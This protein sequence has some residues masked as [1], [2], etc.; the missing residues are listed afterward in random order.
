MIGIFRNW[1]SARCPRRTRPSCNE[2]LV[3]CRTTRLRVEPLETRDMLS[4]IC[5]M[6]FDDHNGNGVRDAGD[7]G[8]AGWTIILNDNGNGVVDNGEKHAVTGPNGTYRF[9]N[10]TAPS[11]P[12]RADRLAR[13][14]RES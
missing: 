13:R 6:K 10:A 3:R 9:G 14:L 5:G 1:L 8:L 4:A 7:E 12:K 11:S 2:G